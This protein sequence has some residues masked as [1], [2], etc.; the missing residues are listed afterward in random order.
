MYLIPPKKLKHN[1]IIKKYPGFKKSKVNSYN[2]K[3]ANMLS[4][5]EIEDI[6]KQYLQ[7]N[8]N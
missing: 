4:K 2:S 5:K 3:Y 6:I 7:T 8:S 1:E